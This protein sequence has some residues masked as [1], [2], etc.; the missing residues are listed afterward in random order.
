MASLSRKFIGAVQDEWQM[1]SDRPRD[2]SVG[3]PIGFGASSI[4][5]DAVYRPPP[6]QR[7]VQCALKVLDLDILSPRPLSLLQRETQL[8]S[9]SKHPNVLRV[10]GSWIDGHKLHIA[11]R[12]MN[13][14]SAADIMHYGW[15]G[16]MEE[17]VSNVSSSRLLRA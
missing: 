7:P 4:V 5:Y 13:K 14:G 8:M 1:F 6:P 16:G 17:E 12:L 15:P 10:R 3:A 9:L 11:L 2:Y